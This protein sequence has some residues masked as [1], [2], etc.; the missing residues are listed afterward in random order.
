MRQPLIK[1]SVQIILLAT[2]LISL[3]TVTACSD[4]PNAKAT[5]GD[6]EAIAAPPPGETRDGESYRVR[7]PGAAGQDTIFQVI[8]PQVFSGD[9]SYPLVLHVAGFGNSRATSNDDEGVQNVGNIKR[10]TNNGYGVISVDMRGHGESGGLIR[11][12]DPDAEMQDILLVLDW[13]EQNLS[14]IS[15]RW[16][17]DAGQVNMVLGAVGASYGGQV[18]LL[19]HAVDPKKRLD[20]MVP[21]NTWNDLSQALVTNDVLKSGWTKLLFGAGN[22]AGDRGNFD[23]YITEILLAAENTNSMPNH[24]KEFLRYH[25][26]AYFCEGQTVATNGGPGTMPLQAPTAPTPIPT[27]LTQGLRDTLFTYNDA[28]KNY[29]CLRQVGSQDVRLITYNAGHNTIFPGPGV[30]Y[31]D[32]QPAGTDRHCASLTYDDAMLAFLDEHLKLQTG[33]LQDVFTNQHDVGPEDICLSLSVNQAIIMHRDDF[34]TGGTAFSFNN[35]TITAAQTTADTATAV[36]TGQYLAGT[37]GAV[38]AG[39]PTAEITLASSSGLG[40]DPIIM[41][42]VGHRRAGNDPSQGQGVWDVIDNQ[43]TPIRGVGTHTIELTAI[44]EQ[45]QPGDELAILLF[46][47]YITHQTSGTRETASASMSVSGTVNLPILDPQTYRDAP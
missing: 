36:A 35:A 9:T 46:G 15:Q 24:G 22:N 3:L 32:P 11:V 8:E 5:R 27:L 25:S 2:A 43:V 18:Q 34:V 26:F 13:A 44:A 29:Q 28:W 30:A 16:D 37:D 47:A 7:I 21:S 40:S 39:I 23:P 20:A 4:S 31:Q 10:L 19:L 45:L 17:D 41:L 38:I 33:R 12:D 14:W 42:G 6:N 1:P